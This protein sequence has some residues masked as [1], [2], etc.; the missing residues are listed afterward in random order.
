M[1]P[2]AC[3]KCGS[4][5]PEAAICGIRILKTS[6]VYAELSIAVS[7]FENARSQPEKSAI[8]KMRTEIEEN[9][10]L[11]WRW[12]HLPIRENIMDDHHAKFNRHQTHPKSSL[13]SPESDSLWCLLN[14]NLEVKKIIISIVQWTKLKT[15]QCHNCSYV[16][17][18][19]RENHNAV[20]VRG[21]HNST[22]MLCGLTLEHLKWSIE[23]CE[24]PE[25]CNM[26]HEWDSRKFRCL[27]QDKAQKWI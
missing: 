24:K 16:R 25:T 2:W 15:P 6:C 18:Y 5:T 11:S 23:F 10:V 8:T 21:S 19:Q 1:Y 22:H 12:E 20:V 26:A 17:W 3:L 13:S 7:W 9:I 4:V 14:S 27:L